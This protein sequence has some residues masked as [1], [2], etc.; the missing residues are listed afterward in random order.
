MT[1]GCL[2]SDIFSPP[3]KPLMLQARD[4]LRTAAFARLGEANKIVRALA[5][6]YGGFNAAYAVY[7]EDLAYAHYMNRLTSL[8]L[9]DVPLGRYTTFNRRFAISS[10]DAVI[11]PSTP[12]AVTVP[13]NIFHR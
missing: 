5:P 4:V 2:T 1:L 6:K 11:R 9:S 13:S 12:G 10:A 3:P 8:N 7:V